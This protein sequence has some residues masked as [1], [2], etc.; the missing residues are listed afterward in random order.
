MSTVLSIYNKMKTFP[1]GNKLF[2]KMLCIK[3]PY[4]NSIHP[5]IT[6]LQPG[7]CA[8]EMKDR[9]SVRNHLGT[10]HAIAMCNLCE[11]VMGLAADTGLPKELRWIPRGMTV[12]YKKIARGTLTG[13]CRIDTENLKEGDIDLP[14]DIIDSSGNTV[15]TAT[16]VL[17]IS[18]KK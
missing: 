1:F 15:T 18:R 17:Y 13:I 2:S 5:L 8:C 16:V 10:I 7:Y 3:A 9:R 14:I 4:F 6:E 12:E 11:L